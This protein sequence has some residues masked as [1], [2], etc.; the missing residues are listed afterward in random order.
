MNGLDRDSEPSKGM[1]ML[2]G[3]ALHTHRSKD[4]TTVSLTITVE[5]SKAQPEV[6]LVACTK[7]KGDQNV[8]QLLGAD[9]L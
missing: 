3:K 4:Q 9:N 8:P 6:R 7:G 2:R 5:G 1:G